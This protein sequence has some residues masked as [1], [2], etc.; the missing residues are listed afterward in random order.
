MRSAEAGAIH[1]IGAGLAGLAA[2]VRL[3]GSNRKIALHEGGMVAG[4]RCRSY[5]D[6]ATGMT[7]DNGTHIVLSGNH[8]ALAFAKTIGSISGLLSAA[9]T[10][11]PFVDLKDK[12][13]WTFGPGDSRFPWWIFDKARRVPE[14]GIADYLALARLA[15]PSADKPGG[16]MVNCSGPAY[17]RLLE[18]FLLAALNIAPHQGSARLAGAVIRETIAL[19]GQSCRPLLARDG[20]GTVFVDPALSYLREHGASV[21]FQNELVGIDFSN[22]RAT[23]LV[24]SNARTNLAEN[25]T[26][27][28]AVPPYIAANLLPG[29][30]TPAAF[31]GILNAHFRVDPPA[32]MPPM[33]GVT[34]GTCEWI[35]SLPGRMA[36][37]VSD[38]DRLFDAPRKQVAELLWGEVAAIAGL[39]AALPLWQIIRERRATFAATPEQ[40]ALRP[41]AETA[42]HNLFLA[43]DWTATGL[44]ATLEG[45]VRSGNRAA[46]LAS[47]RARAAA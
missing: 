17:R 41:A 4:G 36:V 27:I 33:L 31:R 23:Q 8:A 32:H 1:V 46:D 38:A 11:F 2:A 13:R 10:E 24:F 39:P 40:N 30:R 47:N 35:F 43:G 15:L 20:I 12:T 28:L 34:N 3:A 6:H 14:T 26:V 18:P 44:P 7:I 5:Y 25:D 42:W 19:G 21:I 29:L 22:Q 37:T 45:A 16:Q 9:D